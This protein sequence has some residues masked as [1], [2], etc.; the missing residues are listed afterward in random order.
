MCFHR[1]STK[2]QPFLWTLNVKGKINCPRTAGAEEFL[3]FEPFENPF[4]DPFY[5]RNTV[6]IKFIDFGRFTRV[7]TL[8]PRQIIQ[9]QSGKILSIL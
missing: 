6:V 2:I 5:Q 9:D 8:Y 4:M 3:I 1:I 7:G